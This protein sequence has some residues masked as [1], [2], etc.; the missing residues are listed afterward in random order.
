MSIPL[1]VGRRDL[2]E[3]LP[4]RGGYASRTKKSVKAVTALDWTPKSVTRII[5][6]F[7]EDVY[8]GKR[9]HSSLG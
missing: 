7:I 3:A 8:N 9:L 2:D 5:G 1:F 6:A 4:E